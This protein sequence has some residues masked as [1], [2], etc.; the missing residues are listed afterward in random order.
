M[1]GAFAFLTFQADRGTEVESL[2]SLVFH[3]ARQYGWDADYGFGIV[4]VEEMLADAAEIAVGL[5]KRSPELLCVDLPRPKV[6]G[7]GLVRPAHQPRE[8]AAALMGYRFAL[9]SAY[10]DE[11]AW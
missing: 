10:G 7:E 1:P 4:S 6:L 8:V 9:I 3:V 2:G 5:L 11:G